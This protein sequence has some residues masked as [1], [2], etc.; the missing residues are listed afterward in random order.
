MSIWFYLSFV[1][2]IGLLALTVALFDE[3]DFEPLGHITRFVLIFAF[4]IAMINGCSRAIGFNDKEIEYESRNIES[5]S[6]NSSV[7]GEAQFAFTIGYAYIDELPYYYFYEERA[8]GMYMN[9][10]SAMHSVLIESDTV[11][12]HIEIPKLMKY[13]NPNALARLFR[14]QKRLDDL[15]AGVDF[16][17][18][19]RSTNGTIRWSDVHIS[20][21]SLV[22]IY[23]PV[24]TI[25]KQYNADPAL[26]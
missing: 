20:D 1:L 2:L 17:T 22:K 24:G 19:R 16:Y 23:V 15:A 8:G 4:S 6:L 25:K 10:V 12:P 13:K 11:T 9:T 3:N 21:D 5:L 18:D 7:H 14:T 26:L